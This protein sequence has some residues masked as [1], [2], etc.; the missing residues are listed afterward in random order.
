MADIKSLQARL[1]RLEKELER[2]KDAEEEAKGKEAQIKRDLENV[3][4]KLNSMSETRRMH[5]D[6]ALKIQAEINLL[7]RQIAD[8]E[9][10]AT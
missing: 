5:S 10:R 4:A 7:E 6:K 9:R 3:Q 8:E 2:E 1:D